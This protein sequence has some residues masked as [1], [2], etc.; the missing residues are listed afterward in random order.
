MTINF[1]SLPQENP[2][3]LPE[4]GVYKA[5]IVEAEMKQLS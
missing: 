2:F 5:K 1:D 3:A 4:P